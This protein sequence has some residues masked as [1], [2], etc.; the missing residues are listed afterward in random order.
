MNIRIFSLPTA[1]LLALCPMTHALAQISLKAGVNIASVA[2]S[3][4]EP[5]YKELENKSVVGFQVGLAFDLAPKSVISLQPELL[6]IQKGGKATYE[7]DERNRIE[8]RY[9]YNYVEVPLLVKLKLM[10]EETRS[11]I[12]LLAG[13]YLGLALSGKSK[14]TITLLGQTTTSED[15]FT[16]DNDTPEERQRRMD[17]G[18]SFGGG[19]KFGS[20]YLDLRYNLGI[21]NLLDQDANNQND[22]KP[23]RRN[24]GIGITLG[25][26]F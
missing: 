12:Y 10:G 7:L 16:F 25:Y 11:G 8:S 22:D 20:T 17:W 13:P 24:R 3:A 4:K 15:K 26:D 1:V 23:Y 6:Y 19:I 18:V 5:N 21:N 9:Y 14:N 2:E